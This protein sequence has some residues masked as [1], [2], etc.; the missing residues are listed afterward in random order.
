MTVESRKLLASEALE[1]KVEQFNGLRVKKLINKINNNSTFQRAF[2]LAEV[3]ITLGII[4]VV[5]TLTIPTLIQNHRKHVVE[6]RLKKA[7]S[8][9]SQA[10][11]L[12]INDHGMP[13]TWDFYN[14]FADFKQANEYFAKN[15]LF[16]Y[17]K[18]VKICSYEE[19]T[20][21]FPFKY[22]N[23]AYN[24]ILSNGTA[25]QTWVDYASNCGGWVLVDING[26]D[27]GENRYGNGK[28]NFEIKFVYCNKNILDTKSNPIKS[29]VYLNGLQFATPFTR[30]ELKE[31][32]MCG[33]LIQI[34]GWKIS[35][36][37][38]CWK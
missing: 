32:K 38:P 35:D 33:A 5:A 1:N 16:P 3:L 23:Q 9:I 37:N 11:Q 8:E 19:T 6:T 13:E 4:G 30:D 2:T 17:L 21:C 36:D 27:K 14:G 22:G 26:K 28:D 7:Y 18:T 24:A 10:L 34:D 15:Y 25:I 20:D 12:A 29:G 31:R